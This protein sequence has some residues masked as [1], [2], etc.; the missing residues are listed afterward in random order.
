MRDRKS[1]V[2]AK[3]CLP[4]AKAVITVKS[5]N[6]YMVILSNWQQLSWISVKVRNSW[7]PEKWFPLQVI[8]V[9]IN[10]YKSCYLWWVMKMPFTSLFL[11]PRTYTPTL[12]IWRH[13]TYIPMEGLS[14]KAWQYFS[15]LSRLLKTKK[16]WKKLPKIAC[17]GMTTKCNVVSGIRH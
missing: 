13:D 2:T 17:L 8:K 3:I 11:L 15:K 6:I 9:N 12:I 14:V 5:R 4:E 1:T 16:V 10:I 7:E